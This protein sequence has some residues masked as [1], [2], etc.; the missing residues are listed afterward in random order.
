MTPSNKSDRLDWVDSFYRFQ[1]TYFEVYLGDLTD[2]DQRR[3]SLIQHYFPKG[4]TV[5]ELGGGGGQ[6][7]C[8]LSQNGF[9]VTMVEIQQQSVQ[10]A[11]VLM[12]KYATSWEVV[13]GDFYEVDI[14]EQ[15]DVI[16][17]FDSFGIGSDDDQIR[18]LSR[19]QHW[20]KDDGMAF[21]EVGNKTFWRDIAFGRSFNLG[22]AI[23][24]YDYDFEND[25][26]MDTWML[27]APGR[28]TNIQ[29]LR[30]YST[31]EMDDLLM[32][33]NLC[34]LD[35]QPAGRL[36]FEREEFTMDATISN[37]MTYYSLIKKG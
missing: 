36:D 37:C 20:L 26:L 22:P 8:L 2:H 15:F 33:S 32:K 21:V 17:Y 5:L 14:N 34:A 16:C 19:I 23:R 3:T 4:S 13:L 6:T 7:A 10:H 24:T 30:C 18:L 1:N 27:N 35:Y 11:E 25:I 12:Q 29:Q 28:Q 31:H 9:D